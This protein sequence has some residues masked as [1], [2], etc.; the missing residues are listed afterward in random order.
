MAQ[1]LLIEFDDDEE[2]NRLYDQVDENKGQT[3]RVVGKYLHPGYDLCR[4]GKDNRDLDGSLKRGT[5]YRNEGTGML[6]CLVCMKVM[7]GSFGCM[8][9]QV[10][11]EDIDN[12]HTFNATKKGNMP[13]MLRMYNYFISLVSKR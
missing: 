13:N 1:Y 10:K 9:N 7:E 4:C 2:A 5:Y 6:V 12:P 11:P 8:K 3:M